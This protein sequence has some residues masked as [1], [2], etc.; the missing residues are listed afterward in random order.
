M[1][2]GLFAS[3][4]SLEAYQQAHVMFAMRFHSNRVVTVARY[5]EPTQLKKHPAFKFK[6]NQRLIVRNV[7]WYGISLRVIVLKIKHSTKG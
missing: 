7:E 1:A 6:K 4:E 2:D 3:R 5:K